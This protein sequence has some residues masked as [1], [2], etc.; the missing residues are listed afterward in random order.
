MPKHPVLSK[1]LP[2]LSSFSG[3]SSFFP[4]LSGKKLEL[5]KKTA[6]FQLE[7]MR[8][9]PISDENL[10]VIAGHLHHNPEDWV[11]IQ[12]NHSYYLEILNQIKEV[13]SLVSLDNPVILEHPKAHWVLVMVDEVVIPV[14]LCRGYESLGVYKT[15]TGSA[16]RWLEDMSESIHAIIRTQHIEPGIIAGTK[17]D[18][19]RHL[20]GGLH[21][22]GLETWTK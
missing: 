11:Y 14:I 8:S 5:V 22:E 21:L 1:V 16:C 6:Q 7:V 15:V 9:L 19:Y 13:L 4:D 3:L 18:P 2:V 17:E 12:A 10:A 20:F